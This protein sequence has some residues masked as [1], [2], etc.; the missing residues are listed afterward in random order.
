MIR[1]LASCAAAAVLLVAALAAPSRPA[2]AEP[3]PRHRH[4]GRSVYRYARARLT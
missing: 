3:G 2:A 1:R 4:V